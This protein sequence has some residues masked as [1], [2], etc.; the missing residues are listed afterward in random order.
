MVVGLLAALIAAVVFGFATLI[1][2]TA[3]RRLPRE[4]LDL[5]L[6]GDLLRTPAFLLAVG[7]NLVGF[8]LHLVALRTIPLYLAQSGVAASLAVTALLAHR[9]LD[10]PLSGRD[11]TAVAAI[12]GG[13]AVMAL[14]AGDVG[15]VSP[16]DGFVVGMYLVLVALFLAGTAAVRLQGAAAAVLL[17]FLAGVGFAGTGIGTRIIPSLAPLDVLTSPETYL[18][19]LCGILAFSLYSLALQ[20][21]SVTG[22]TAP[23][24]VMQ[25]VTPALVGLLLLDDQ[26]RD[27]WLIV[28][29]IGFVASVSGAI[30]LARFERGPGHAPE[31]AH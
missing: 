4:G 8:V 13:L 10:E 19:C 6:V 9:V 27:G 31:V 22:A 2:A 23:M 20:R 29:L 16:P 17:G 1:Q 15:D 21:G 3:V 26:V 12:C 5:R 28:S 11:W 14:G 25:T 30:A 18:V 7:L 24:I